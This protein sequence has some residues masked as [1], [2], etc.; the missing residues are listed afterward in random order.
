VKEATLRHRLFVIL[1]LLTMAAVFV[2]IVV[3]TVMLVWPYKPLTVHS[4][5]I[6]NPGSTVK[7]GETLVLRVDYT[8]PKDIEGVGVRWFIDGI[9]YATPPTVGRVPPGEGASII[10]DVAVPLSL[11]PGVYRLKNVVEFQVN[12]LRKVTYTYSTAT[13]TVTPA[14]A[15][16]DAAQDE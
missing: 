16:P 15:H 8:K 7:Q 11:P 4:T 6:L 1:A 13:F 3:V 2:S 14:V 5:E 10:R 12:V 9:A